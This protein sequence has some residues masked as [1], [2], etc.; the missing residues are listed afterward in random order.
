M[1]CQDIRVD[2]NYLVT[3][4]RS[5]G[6][7]RRKHTV[8]YM[9]SNIDCKNSIEASGVFEYLKSIRSVSRKDF[10]LWHSSVIRAT[11]RRNP[12]PHQ[13]FSDVRV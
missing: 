12:R 2:A 10:L 11:L 9:P 1:E 5:I 4:N 6:V 3:T 8:C 13:V 7:Y